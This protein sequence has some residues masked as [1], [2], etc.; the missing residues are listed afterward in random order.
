MIDL[1]PLFY[2]LAGAARL[3]RLDISGAHMMVGG[4]RGFWA[5]IYW[6]A[7]LALPL[8]FLLMLLRYDPAKHDGWRYIFVHGEIYIIA[9][10]VFPL[11]MDHVCTLLNR[12]EKYLKFII[13]YNWLNCFY[14][15]FY[16][17]IGLAQASGMTS[18]EGASAASVGMMLAG[19]VWIGYLTRHT[20]EIPYSAAVG[21]VVLDLFLSMMISMLS[22][23]LLA[24]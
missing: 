4:A 23:A 6:S 9:W 8:F 16:L 20:L 21:I 17:I 19:I 11:V 13:A 15:I 14:N 24:G 22:A 12:R 3:M 7:G 2:G 1:R 18:W 5:S 10:L